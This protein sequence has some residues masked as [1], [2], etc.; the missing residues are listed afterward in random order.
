MDG[1]HRCQSSLGS[2][3]AA[4]ASLTLYVDEL[5]TY[6][7]VDIR[8][9]FRLYVDSTS[10]ISNVTTT[11]RD[12]IPK[13]RF[14]NHADI[15]ST[16]SSAHNVIEYF[17]M[18]HAHRHQDDTKRFDELPFPA[19]LNVLCDEMATTQLKRQAANA[20]ERTLSIPLLP[21]NLNVEVKYGR[22]VISSHYVARLRESISLHRH[23]T[24]LQA[25]YKR[26]DQVWESIAWDAF[27]TCA[28]QPKL[29][30]P[31]NRSKL[32]HNWL[33]LG[34]QRAKFGSGGSTLEIERS[35]P[36]CKQAEDFSA[37]AHMPRTLC[38]QVP[39]RCFD[40]IPQSVGRLW[41]QWC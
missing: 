3:A 27:M 6:H 35:C 1:W 36:Y 11:L 8:Y 4:I 41:R 22:Q 14:P 5:A 38:P 29:D 23:R 34:A 24:F 19:Q 31:I 25:K 28:C 20:E 17:V 12:L 21:R 18:T 26:S 37:S 39:I 33:N 40:P 15:L 16:M 30:Q 7:Q 9:K 2:E 10:A 32:V 13:R